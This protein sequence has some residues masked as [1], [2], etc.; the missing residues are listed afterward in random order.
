MGAI[1]EA[2]TVDDVYE[3]EEVVVVGKSSKAAYTGDVP[4]VGKA[5]KNSSFSL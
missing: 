1:F 2:Q 3:V 5:G 4:G